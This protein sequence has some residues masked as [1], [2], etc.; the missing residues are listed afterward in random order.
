[1]KK[2]RDIVYEYL[3]KETIAT[4][5]TNWKTDEIAEAL[6]M[7]RTNVSTLLNE[8]TAEGLLIKSKT[9]PVLYKVASRT[10]DSVERK[11][12][13][14]LVG[15]DGSLKKAVDDVKKALMYPADSLNIQVVTDA[16][17]GSTVFCNDIYYYGLMMG[18]FG[19]NS[20]LIYVNCRHF[21]K[22]RSAL[23]D[24]IFGDE[25]GIEKSAF[26]Q[27][28]GGVLFID[29]VELLEPEQYSRI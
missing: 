27:A 8:L 6:N 21:K 3:W 9:R 15:F 14:E 17:S 11:P 28:M 1:M 26:Y 4:G 5:K 29:H 23:N 22:N 25:S 7:Q 24:V 18:K 13:E 2:N 16:G 19:K 20:P 12:F 10:P